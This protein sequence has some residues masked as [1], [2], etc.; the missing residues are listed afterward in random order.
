LRHAQVG[1]TIDQGSP[2]DLPAYCSDQRIYSD[3]K[4]MWSRHW[5]FW[6]YFHWH[7]QKLSHGEIQ[8]KTCFHFRKI[9]AFDRHQW[10]LCIAIS[11][12]QFLSYDGPFNLQFIC[13]M[14]CIVKWWSYDFFIIS[15]SPI[16]LNRLGY[17]L[18]NL[19]RTHR[20]SNQNQLTLKYANGRIF[21]TNVQSKVSGESWLAKIS[22]VNYHGIVWYA[23]VTK[24]IIHS[25]S[26]FGLLSVMKYYLNGKQGNRSSK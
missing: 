18:P 1:F 6:V 15:W 20:L 24:L 13:F 16:L 2:T 26:Q 5:E 8:W 23:R 17:N 12:L 19:W 4:G 7:G 22:D 3:F 9:A 25:P 11:C 21:G 14:D 10:S